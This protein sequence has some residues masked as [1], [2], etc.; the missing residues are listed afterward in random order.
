[1]KRKDILTK[2]LFRKER[3]EEIDLLRGFPI[4]LVV[5]YHFCWSFVSLI[6]LFSNSQEMLLQYR[7]LNDFVNFL[8]QDILGSDL[9]HTLLVPI[10]GGMFIFVCGISSIF[11]RSNK[12]RALLLWAG[13]L[14]ITICTMIATYVSKEDCY[15]DF[16][17]LHLMAFS[18]TVYA[19]LE[20]LFKKVFKKRVSIQVCLIIAFGIFFFSIIVSSGYNPF[21]K[22][23]FT[24]WGTTF[25][26]NKPMP[27][28]RYIQ[29]PSAFFLEALGKYGGWTDWWSIFP[30]TG[31]FFAG[32][33][34]GKYL[35]EEKKRSIMPW[36]DKIVIFR[37]ICFCG[38]HTIW[39]YIFHQPIIVVI[40]F[41]VFFFMG[42]RI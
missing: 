12:R 36:L 1:M 37:P 20:T 16:G 29:N 39:I 32:V 41:I 11:T 2:N 24:P 34:L 10:F 9:I 33:S 31:V 6:Y 4:F 35:Y 5:L 28:N 8:N 22:E 27:L 17:V 26:D 3:I 30:Y 21:T 13:A 38:K 25:L 40:L 18:V 14:L 19:L 15:I 23:N 7:N 42:F